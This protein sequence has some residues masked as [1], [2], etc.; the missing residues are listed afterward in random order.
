MASTDREALAALFH[1]TD[2]AEWTNN[3]NWNT[4]AELS[5]WYGVEVNGEGLV[6]KLSLNANNLRGMPTPGK[7]TDTQQ[8]LF[9][10]F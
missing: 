6:V 1:S 10:F 5:T 2:G 8:A 9:L 7:N 4:D 3:D